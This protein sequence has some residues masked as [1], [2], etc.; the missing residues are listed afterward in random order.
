M[1]QGVEMGPA[2]DAGQLRTDLEAIAQAR[3]EGARLLCGG[4]RLSSAEHEHGFFLAPTIFD[5]VLPGTKLA[6]EEV[7]GPVLAIQHARD[8]EEAGRIANDVAFGLTA[9]IYTRDY[10]Q[11]MRFVGKAEGG[12]VQGNQPTVGGGAE[13]PFGGTTGDGRGG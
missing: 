12:V 13:V 6:T 2:V 8:A 1:Q 7:F 9:A 4:E 3:S 5:Q 10:F 11:A